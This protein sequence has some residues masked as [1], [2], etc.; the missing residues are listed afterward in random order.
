M[1]CFPTPNFGSVPL[2]LGQER[3][4]NQ[5]GKML[6]VQKNLV[7]VFCFPTRQR[8]NELGQNSPP[9]ISSLCFFTRFS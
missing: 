4:C 3:V 6:Q 9:F 8:S 2:P 1:L 7:P 5:E